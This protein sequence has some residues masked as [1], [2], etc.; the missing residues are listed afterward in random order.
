MPSMFYHSF[1]VIFIPKI[2]PLISNGSLVRRERKQKRKLSFSV[3]IKM[4][5]RIQTRNSTILNYSFSYIKG[6][7]QKKASRQEAIEMA[8]E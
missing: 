4:Q 2:V 7:Q 5:M 1:D 6:R 3:V 8:K